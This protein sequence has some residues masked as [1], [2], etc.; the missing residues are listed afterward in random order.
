MTSPS[1]PSSVS[2][3]S[4]ILIGTSGF[5]YDDWRGVF[6]PASL[7]RGDM[8]DYYAQ[9]FPALEIN[10]TYYTTPGR[11]T[12]EGMVRRAAGRLTF[13]IKA[14]G[15]LTHKADTS[16]DVIAPWRRF[17]EPFAEAGTLAAVLLQYP[18]G[19]HATPSEWRVLDATRRKLA[20]LPLVIELRHTSWDTPDTRRQFADWGV[21]RA[22]VDQPGNVR[23]LSQSGALDLAGPLAYVRFHGRN[24]ASWYGGEEA[25]S[26]YLYRYA[27]GELRPWVGI[28]NDAAPKAQTTLAF[29][30]NHPQGNAVLDAQSLATMLGERL[31]TPA[32]G[33]LFG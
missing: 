15:A 11:A 9:I 17:V 33:D 1:P 12:A 21:S 8:L 29:F 31:G 22:M 32:Q 3:R 16:D 5:A 18:A 25:S 19:F 6:Y 30:N 27:E 7:R 20:P 4:R 2:P 14:P 23:G 28:I 24:A 10:A 13:A 26:R